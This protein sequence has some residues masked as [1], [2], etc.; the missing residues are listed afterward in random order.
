MAKTAQQRLLVVDDKPDFCDFVRMTGEKM[1]Y[2]VKVAHNGIA[3]KSTYASF[4]PTNIVLD[5]VMPDVDGLE[6][7]HWLA[8]QNCTA[9]I[10]VVTGVEPKFAEMA[11]G[12]GEARG[13]AIRKFLKPISL[14]DLRK[15]LAA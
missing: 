8:E 3:F 6:L 11:R 13:L 2:Q 1:G 15:A 9:A 14:G 4:N 10:M 5:V 7:I 12:L